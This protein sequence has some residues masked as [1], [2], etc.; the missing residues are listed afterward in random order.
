MSAVIVLIV[1]G[2]K[3]RLTGVTHLENNMCSV[4]SLCDPID[5]SPPGFS[6]H[7]IIQERI[8]EWVAI[9]SSKV[10]SRAR[11]RTCISC[12]F[13]TSRW[14]LYYCDIWEAPRKWQEYPRSST[15][16]ICPLSSRASCLLPSSLPGFLRYKR[17]D[18]TT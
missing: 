18:F 11:D 8:L 14:I 6:V 4:V 15:Q 1:F 9:S 13:C 3:L 17:D 16:A 12:I 5:Y 10:S 2:K 7:G